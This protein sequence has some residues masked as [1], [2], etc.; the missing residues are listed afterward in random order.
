MNVFTHYSKGLVGGFSPLFKLRKNKLFK[1]G[2][3]L[4]FH[5]DLKSSFKSIR[6]HA[7]RNFAFLLQKYEKE[8][9]WEYALEKQCCQVL[10]SKHLSSGNSDADIKLSI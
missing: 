6:I 2:C 3:R 8:A 1:N 5:F 9:N 7:H 4:T 10:D